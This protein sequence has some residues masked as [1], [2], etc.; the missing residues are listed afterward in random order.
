MPFPVSAY[1]LI[2]MKVRDELRKIREAEGSTL[3]YRINIVERAHRRAPTTVHKGKD[4]GYMVNYYLR[5]ARENYK[6]LNKEALEVTMETKRVRRVLL[7]ESKDIVIFHEY[8][9]YVN[10]LSR[11]NCKLRLDQGTIFQKKKP[12]K[13]YKRKDLLWKNQ[14]KF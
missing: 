4:K 14:K 9:I 2:N 7:D 5:V 6:E 13:V 1:T 8:Y 12:P 3:N 10:H 11:A